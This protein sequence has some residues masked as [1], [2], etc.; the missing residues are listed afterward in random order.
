MIPATICRQHLTG[1]GSTRNSGNLAQK[2]VLCEPDIQFSYF[3]DRGATLIGPAGSDRAC[4]SWQ[5]WRARLAS[6]FMLR[7][8]QDFAWHSA[9]IP[10]AEDGSAYFSRGPRESARQ[11]SKRFVRAL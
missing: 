8:Q 10:A 5:L 9:R 2:E 4:N 1:L 7:M 3:L 6:S 11:G